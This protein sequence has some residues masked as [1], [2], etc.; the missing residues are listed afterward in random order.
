[1]LGGGGMTVVA[2]FVAGVAFGL[3]VAVCLATGDGR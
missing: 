1:M 3:Y 2:L